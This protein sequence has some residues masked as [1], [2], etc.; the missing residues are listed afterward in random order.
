MSD[1][2]KKLQEMKDGIE[3]MEAKR[4]EAFQ[5]W[6]AKMKEQAPAEGTAPEGAAT[7]GLMAKLKEINDEREVMDAR[8]N[9]P[10]PRGCRRGKAFSVCNLS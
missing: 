3:S 2:T 5:E 9:A 4:E 8:G 6:L 7:S 1:F 10:Q